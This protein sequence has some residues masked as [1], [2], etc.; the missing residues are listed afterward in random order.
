[1]N[2]LIS[3]PRLEGIKTI[4]WLTHLYSLRNKWLISLPRLEGIKTAGR[5]HSFET[6]LRLISLPRLEGIKTTIGRF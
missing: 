1:M 3:L 5:F 2:W 4:P 6:T